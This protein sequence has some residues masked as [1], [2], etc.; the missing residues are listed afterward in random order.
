MNVQLKRG[1]IDVCVLAALKDEA[2]YGYKIISDL[3][4][5]IALSE[6]T[7]YPVLKRLEGQECLKT[8]TKDFNGRLRKYYQITDVGKRRIKEFVSEWEE[9]DKVLHFIS[10]K[11]GIR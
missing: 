1:L 9:I 7:L 4:S 2:S 10:S 5:V 3:E 8:Y 11:G 6:S